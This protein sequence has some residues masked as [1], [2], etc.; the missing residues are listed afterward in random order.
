MQ[1]AH[2]LIRTQHRLD[3]DQAQSPL[4][5]IFAAAI[6]AQSSYR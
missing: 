4:N 6:I 2:T 3:E 1:S 5:M